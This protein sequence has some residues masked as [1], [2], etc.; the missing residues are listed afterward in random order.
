MLLEV[1]EAY[2]LACSVVTVFLLL[3]FTGLYI[4]MLRCISKQGIFSFLCV[5]VFLKKVE[6][7]FSTAGKCAYLPVNH[8][9]EV[10]NLHANSPD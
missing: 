3:L 8:D 7:R 10:F 1:H 5:N 2:F 6:F 9:L 4:K